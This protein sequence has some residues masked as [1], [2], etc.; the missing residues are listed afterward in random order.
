M[1][2]LY[3]GGVHMARVVFLTSLW[4]LNVMFSGCFED[5]IE[6]MDKMDHARKWDIK[7]PD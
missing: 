5:I 7:N 2:K 4:I 3:A 1:G 6:R